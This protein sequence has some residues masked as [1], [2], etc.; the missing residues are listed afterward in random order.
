MANRPKRIAD[1]ELAEA[2]RSALHGGELPLGA[3]VRAIRA[4]EGESQVDL[5][6]RAGVHVKVIKALESGH[7]N[8]G[9]SSLSK[10]AAAAKLRVALVGVSSI[11]LMDPDARA[12]EE[13]SI[14]EAEARAIASG[15]VSRRELHERNALRV[16]EKQFELPSF[17]SIS[18][19]D[20]FE[21]FIDRQVESGRYGS[22]S[23]VVRASLRLLEER[24]QK[25]VALRQAL[26]DGEASGDAGLLDM[27]DIKKKAR[28]RVKP[29]A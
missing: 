4:L 11:E 29:G 22:A 9:L 15:K 12:G 2:L 8:P 19:G 6:E 14:R 25:I 21:G 3:A 17:P 27:D 10:I 18:L 28:R 24:E 16:D 13:R 26:I 7:G 20:H 1:P 23:E 5:A